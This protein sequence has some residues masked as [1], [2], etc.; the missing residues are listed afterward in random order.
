MRGDCCRKDGKQSANVGVR[1][2]CRQHFVLL[3]M[4]VRVQKFAPILFLLS[5]SS[6]P[7]CSS[8]GLRYFLTNFSFIA[9]I[10]IIFYIFLL[11]FI[12]STSPYPL[13]PL[14]SS[15][16]IPHISVTLLD[17]C[18]L[19]QEHDHFL[20]MVCEFILKRLFLMVPN[21]LRVKENWC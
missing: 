2:A 11:L 8:S 13:S 14:Y 15:H 18:I 16:V 21:F 7:S 3:L 20:S 6:S 5:S 19:H 1:I 4:C 9:I 10:I 17:F 12:Y